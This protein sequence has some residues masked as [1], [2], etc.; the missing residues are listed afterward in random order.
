MNRPMPMGQAPTAS[1]H[2]S[3]PLLGRGEVRHTRLR[4][5][6]HAFRYP[7]YFL[8]LPLRSLAKAEA[9]MHAHAAEAS[10]LV[11][12]RRALLSFY[13]RDHGD[14][15]SDALA[16]LLE[17]LASQGVNDADGEIWLQTYPRVLGYVF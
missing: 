8:M 17:L 16:W 12:N 7:T 9:N 10:T 13:D 4:P 15:R 3:V 5:I 6:H 1:A 11:R 14:G 2:V